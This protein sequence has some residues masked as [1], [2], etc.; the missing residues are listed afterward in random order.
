MLMKMN[1]RFQLDRLV[2]PNILALKPYSCARDEF[3]GTARAMLDA[4]ENARITPF[5]R[6][7]DPLNLDL[8]D[9][10]CQVYGFQD[11]HRVFLGVGS[12]ECI[13]MVYRVF[14]RPGVDN[15]VAMDPSYGMYGVC[16]DINDV[17]YRAVSL[18]PDFSLDPEAILA[19]CDD[20]TKAIFL[21]S[22]NNPTGNCIPD[23]AIELICD[24]FPG[25][26]VIDQAY[27]DFC[28]ATL[29]IVNKAPNAIV[30]RT[31]S[32]AWG[33]AAI[34]LG[35]AFAS[36]EIVAL[37]NK[38]KYPY[39]ISLLTRRE[40]ESVLR[41]ADKVQSIVKQIVEA[42]ERLAKELAKLPIVKKIYPSDAN[43]LLIEVTDAND[44][45]RHLSQEDGIVVR[46]RDSV[47]LCNGCLRITIGTEE[48]N[49]LLINALKVYEK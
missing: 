28:E 9:R 14:C 17:E 25:I 45:Y 23:D 13:D 38:V 19:A 47:H 2:R 11:P 16:A 43:F 27:G 24:R 18:R 1:P 31:F 30:M 44:I 29:D 35:M 34:R 5:N 22:P 15:V 26:V 37:F 49:S 8:K 40:A 7:P 48:E 41:Q 36:R 32:K 21:C 6:Y 3:K 20:R 12:D 42:R 46:N 39:N 4:N 10:I 33:H